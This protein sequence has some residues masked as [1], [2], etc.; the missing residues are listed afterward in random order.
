MLQDVNITNYACQRQTNIDSAVL[1][2]NLKTV[3]Q[4]KL[5]KTVSKIQV[6]HSAFYIRSLNQTNTFM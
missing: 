4:L 1:N 6:H 3:I 2:I 5:T